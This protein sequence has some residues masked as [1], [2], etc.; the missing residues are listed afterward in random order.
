MD[1][2]KIFAINGDKTAMSDTNY[3]TGFATLEGV[4]PTVEL[5][6]NLFYNLDE[7][8][9]DLNTRVTVLET[10]QTWQDMSS[11]RALST[12]YTNDTG[13]PIMVSVGTI[14]NNVM[15]P[16]VITVD[17][18][19]CGGTVIVPNGSSYAVNIGTFTLWSELRQ[20]A[21]MFEIDEETLEIKG[22]QGDSFVGEYG[23]E[24]NISGVTLTEEDVVTFA[25][26]TNTY[27]SNKIIEKTYNG[28]TDNTF[29]VELTKEETAG[30][31]TGD[32]LYD[33]SIVFADSGERNTIVTP[34]AFTVEGVVHDV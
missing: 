34:R 22:R 28:I 7:K 2:S 25:V 3:E 21:N 1:Y 19:N 30:I 24:F 18:I 9:N 16:C 23:F 20:E 6:N 14:S 12:T 27:S 13:K 4:A 26:R 17:G 10:A 11:S 8:A 15:V 29:L 31:G 5:F 33:I 32:Y